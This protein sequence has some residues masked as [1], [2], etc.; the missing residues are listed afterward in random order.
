MKEKYISCG[1]GFYQK[2]FDEVCEE[3]EK[4]EKVNV[5]ICCIGHTLNNMTQDKYK[6]ELVK[7]YGSRLNVKCNEGWCSYSYTYNLID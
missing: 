7:K 3:L 1:N 4:G 5:G 6:E 2:Y